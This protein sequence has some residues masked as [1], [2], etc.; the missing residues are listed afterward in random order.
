[1]SKLFLWGSIASSRVQ[2][3]YP[4]DCHFTR[5]A[6]SVPPASFRQKQ[7]WLSGFMNFRSEIVLR[8]IS[9]GSTSRFSLFCRQKHLMR[10]VWHTIKSR[11]LAWQSILLIICANVTIPMY[12]GTFHFLMNHDHKFR[13]LVFLKKEGGGFWKGQKHDTKYKLDANIAKTWLKIKTLHW[14]HKVLRHGCD[15]SK[16]TLPL[17]FYSAHGYLLFWGPPRSRLCVPCD[18][19]QA[20]HVSAVLTPPH[21][22]ICVICAMW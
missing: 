2:Y 11:T 3:S 5:L 6:S 8:D 17:I 1:M 18:V 21:S 10:T 12:T 14:L 15:M 16:C 9:C 7:E 4:L 19:E 20:A 22:G 13:F